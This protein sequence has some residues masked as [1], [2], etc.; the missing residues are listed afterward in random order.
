MM[1][2][3]HSWK[4]W[5]T[6]PSFLALAEARLNDSFSRLS[7]SKMFHGEGGGFW[8]RNRARGAAGKPLLQR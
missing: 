8:H 5:T 2:F 1:A 6:E 7:A 3:C 4:T